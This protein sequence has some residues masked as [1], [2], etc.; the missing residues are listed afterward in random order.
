MVFYLNKFIKLLIAGLLVAYHHFPEVQE[1]TRRGGHAHFKFTESLSDNQ[2][3]ECSK[4]LCAC[5]EWPFCIYNSGSCVF[6]AC[7]TLIHHITGQKDNFQG[8]KVS[9]YTITHQ[10]IMQ[11]NPGVDYQ[12]V[13]GVRCWLDQWKEFLPGVFPCISQIATLL[14]PQPCFLPATYC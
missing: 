12:P 6:I 10:N 7:A 8:R 3:E 11:I 13:V 5:I 4:L 9:D 2:K 1:N 14:F